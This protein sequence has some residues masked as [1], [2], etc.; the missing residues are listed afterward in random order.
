MF[1][2][3]QQ[4]KNCTTPSFVGHELHGH[5]D[6]WAVPRKF[7]LL[8]SRHMVF[9]IGKPLTSSGVVEYSVSGDVLFLRYYMCQKHICSN[10]TVTHLKAILKHGCCGFYR[11]IRLPSLLSSWLECSNTAVDLL[12]VVA[13]CRVVNNQLSGAQKAQ[14]E[15]IDYLYRLSNYLYQFNSSL[16]RQAREI[17]RRIELIVDN[18]G[19]MFLDRFQSHDCVQRSCCIITKYRSS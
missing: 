2:T 15:L 13:I 4:E 16:N 9:L 1:D 19:Y 17:K 7:K 3:F 11:N 8:K 14:I 10:L 5:T 6:G 12:W 18:S